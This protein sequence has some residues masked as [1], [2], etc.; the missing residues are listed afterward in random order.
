[1]AITKSWA[2][3]P[4]FLAVAAPPSR[5]AGLFP[6]LCASLLIAAGLVLAYAGK[7][8]AFS[9]PAPINVNTITSADELLPILDSVPER[10]ALATAIF[11][12]AQR[13][14]PLP[15]IGALA[16][17]RRTDH[18]PL[19]RLKPLLAVR[20]A[21]DF[22]RELVESTA[23]Y[24]AAF[25]AVA[26][27]WSFSRFGGDRAILPA[28]H[29]LS[30]MGLILMVS[31]RDPLRDTL[32]FHKF[33]V[34][35]AAGCLL[36]ALPALRGFDYMRLADWCYTP[37]FGAL[38]LF[39]LL[40]AFGRGPAG[41]D[42]K[43]NLG[44]FQ[45]VELVKIL[46]VLFLAGYLTLH[47]ERLRDLREKR[48]LPRLFGALGMPRLEHLVPVLGAVAVSL[49]FFFVLKDLGPA[50]CIFF[51]FLAMF[52]AARGRPGLALAGL[53][54]LIGGVWTGYQLG[55]P[56]TVVDRVHMWLAPWDNDVHGGDQL[57]HSLW[58]FAT[59]GP[60]G[61]G[62][63]W[64]D[65]AMIPA[66]HTDLV[67]PAIGE[68]WGF[69]GVASVFALFGFLVAR[70]YRAA[71][72][73]ATRF[74]FFLA[75]GLGS[76][77]AF[78]MLLISAGVLGALPLSGVVSPFLSSGN[79]AML[80]NFLIFALILSVSADAAEKPRGSRLI[81][82]RIS[83][84]AAATVLLGFAA[85]YQLLHDTEFL[86]R[87]AHAFEEDGVKRPQHNP[88]LNSIAREIPRGNIYDRNGV[89]LATSNWS[90]LDR[91]RAGYESLG[92]SLDRAAT[93]FE[94]R[95]YPFGAATAL[96]I[97]D[98]RTGENF[99]ASNASLVEHD[100]NQ[101]LQGYQYAEL[102][103]LVRFRHQPGNEALARVLSR[104][105]DVHLTL[106]IRLQLRARE[107][108]D[109]HL[110]ETANR[111]G[112]AVVMDSTT[113]DVLA[114][115]SAPAPEPPGARSVPPTP[116][117][118]LD[119]ARYGQY[120]P[121]S[122][123]KLVTAIAALRGNPDLKRRTYLCRTLA[124]GRAGNVIAGWNR[125]I[126]D[127]V[128]D[129]AHGTLDMERAIAVSCN[130][131]FAQLGVHDVGSQQLADTA[132]AMG[133]TTGTLA[134]LRKSLP[135]AAYGQGEVVISP[136]K[137]ARVAAT[138]AN[139]GRMPQGRWSTDS[140]N[141][142]TEAATEVLAPAEAAY[143]AGAMRRVVTEGTGRTAMA[144]SPVS[145]AGKTGTA[146]MDTGLPHS[147]FTG[148][149]PY[150]GAPA[151]RLAFAVLV[152]HGGYGTRVA[153]PIAR[154]IIE[155]AKELGLL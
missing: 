30:G 28:L 36:L 99:H 147:W 19:A 94:P 87:D 128:G 47:W 38:G 142:R 82:L 102:A 96:V 123:F 70:A 132:A 49:V 89:L 149:A 53:A 54:L 98:L 131:Y 119:R 77:I 93:R 133:I 155:A 4:T 144:G 7:S 126:K 104:D 9:G 116:D 27:L 74:G 17:L 85:H 18:L 118:L 153:A 127:D 141:D 88:R 111:R 73:S 15:N 10:Q 62:P 138:I 106:D 146:Q 56:H 139:G 110:R 8:Q 43:V 122:T 50:L 120:P 11:D 152:E 26:F 129:R 113:G 14:R 117:E 101:K 69:L 95:H 154:E 148:F 134:E 2:A 71:S 45:P 52:S 3:R 57:A 46:L 83:L 68:E 23:L 40:L 48:A 137:M 20:T 37:L 109:R 80:A 41:N 16:P 33:A 60:T 13:K 86:A 115:V 92:V 105:R 124:D 58:A 61:S 72:R 107:I 103:S 1:M 65:P 63:G 135:F 90:D 29:L 75:L 35:A 67:L 150:D 108:L 78:E 112:A 59:G 143:L 91:R 66:G 79:T 84:G 39:S 136:F 121:G 145:F 114:M 6:L 5:A 22:E 130:A 12:F 24:F 151:H 97:G 140:S 100:A 76:L 31:L 32:E 25:Y 64:G 55:Q 81:P 34:G 125:P 21:H 42:A 51:V 44:P